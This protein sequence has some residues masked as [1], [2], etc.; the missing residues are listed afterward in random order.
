M[1]ASTWSETMAYLWSSSI[2]H[3]LRDFQRATGVINLIVFESPRMS[4][5]GDRHQYCSQYYREFNE[6]AL[7]YVRL[8]ANPSQ[9]FVH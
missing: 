4:S 5:A 3:D 1:I 2:L 6:T 7:M 8:A 9:S